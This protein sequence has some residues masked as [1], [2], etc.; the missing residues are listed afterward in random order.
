MRDTLALFVVCG[1]EVGSTD[2][3]NHNNEGVHYVKLSFDC[4]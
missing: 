2:Y 4:Y 1:G 3:N